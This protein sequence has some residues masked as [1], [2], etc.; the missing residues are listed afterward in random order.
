MALTDRDA[1]NTD[2]IRSALHA[3]SNA[4]AVSIS[5][6]L[7]AFIIDQLRDRNE[8]LLRSPKGELQKIVMS[9][10]APVIADVKV[11]SKAAS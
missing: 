3:R 2:K 4:H 1:T 6:S 5:L 8:L 7:T 10:L 11:L 9:E